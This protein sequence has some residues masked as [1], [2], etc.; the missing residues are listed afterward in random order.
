MRNLLGFMLISLFAALALACGV[1]SGD[2]EAVDRYQQQANEARAE[3]EAERAAAA[4]SKAELDE[5]QEQVA[6]INECQRALS[7]S[8]T[9]ADAQVMRVCGELEVY[10]TMI[11]EVNRVIAA[12]NLA[13]ETAMSGNAQV[14]AD[15]L[16]LMGIQSEFAVESA[17]F[18]RNAWAEIRAS[19][20]RMQ[21]DLTAAQ[22]ET[23]A[24]QARI[25]Q[26]GVAQS[27]SATESSAKLIADLRAERDEFRDDYNSLRDELREAQALLREDRNSA[28]Q[29]EVELERVKQEYDRQLA[30]EVERRTETERQ[31]LEAAERAAN[32]RAAEAERR[33]SARAAAA[34]AQAQEAQRK[35]EAAEAT[36]AQFGQQYREKQAEAEERMT[37]LDG[38]RQQVDRFAA[39]LWGATIGSAEDKLTWMGEAPRNNAYGVTRYYEWRLHDVQFACGSS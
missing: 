24:A 5:L 36:A 37:A 38:C 14:L 33:A 31:R 8:V 29:Q 27:E 9:A 6:Y 4:E 1:G 12:S 26:Q 17:E 20:Q 32:E 3:A 7:D 35:A 28:L 39:D 16:A 30:L 25:E 11:S 10:T 34:E 15:T 22:Q 18:E 23:A 2:A 19:I 21:I 13:N